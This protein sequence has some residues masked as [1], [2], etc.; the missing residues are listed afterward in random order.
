MATQLRPETSTPPGQSDQ[1]D[2]TIVVIAPIPTAAIKGWRRLI[3]AIDPAKTGAFALTGQS[4]HP[5]G[6]YRAQH[7]ALI[8][9]VDT[10]PDNRA[11]RL[12]RVHP[13]GLETVKEWRQKT[14]LGPRVTSFIAKRLPADT[15]RAAPIAGVPNRWPGRCYRCGEE[16]NV[17]AGVAVRINGSTRVSHQDQCPPRPPKSNEKDGCC[18]LC[19]KPVPAGSGLLNREW[20]DLTS[21]PRWTVE[22][23]NNAACDAAPDAFPNRWADWCADCGRLVRAGHGV[24]KDRAV[25]C[26]GSCREPAA[27]PSWRITTSKGDKYATGETIRT[28]VA[29]RPGERPVP[30]EAPGRQI[31][32]EGMVSLIVTVIDTH[33]RGDGLCMAK[34]RAATWDEAAE[35]LAEEID[36]AVDAIPHARGFKAAFA[37]EKIGPGGRGGG[38]DARGC[39]PWL[40]EITGHDR[41]FGFRR[42]FQP[43]R[44]DYL[45]ATNSGSR[46]IWYRWVLSPNTPYEAYRPTKWGGVGERMFLRVT[47]DGD[48]EQITREQVEAMLRHGTAWVD[49][50]AVEEYEA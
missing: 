19:G 43:A 33:T 5:G 23:V 26:Y 49:P 50:C 41:V 48:T 16:L 12:L 9:A 31:L 18:R 34:V 20:D 2:S 36:L 4:L 39:T 35:I 47:P 24:W 46:G 44:R 7:G 37:S 25:R 27:L 6:C 21:S 17:G 3:L 10:Y 40:A 42:A 30:S 45:Q 29:P 22:H 14:P 1:Y 8:I 11:I 15:W 13:G 38:R 28:V 32:D